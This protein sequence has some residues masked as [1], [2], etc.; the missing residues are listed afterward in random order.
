[1]AKYL[2]TA[3]WEASEFDVTSAGKA[4]AVRAWRPPRVLGSNRPSRNGYGPRG[5]SLRGAFEP[6]RR[7]LLPGTDLSIRLSEA[8][9]PILMFDAVV[10]GQRPDGWVTYASRGGIALS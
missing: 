7:R 8:G 9:K 10:T 6:T 1:M 5:I 2:K 3:I 4:V